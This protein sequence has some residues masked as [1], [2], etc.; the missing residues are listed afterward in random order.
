MT[1]RAEDES[2]ESTKIGPGDL[3]AFGGINLILTLSL[4][5]NDLS[6]N[7]INW[8]DLDSLKKLKF[9]RKHKHFWNRVELSSNNE[10]LDILLNI[11]KTSQK[12]IK[13]GYVG[14][15]K[16]VYK[17][18]QIEFEDFIISVAKQNG[19][20]LTSC[21]VCKCTISIQL[22]LKYENQEKI[23]LL[24]G[25][26]TDINKTENNNLENKDLN[27]NEGN[28]NKNIEEDKKNGNNTKEN[29]DKKNGNEEKTE[30]NKEN[31]NNENNKNKEKENSNEGNK[32]ESKSNEE[33]EE[34]EEEKNPFENLADNNINCGEFNYIYFNFNDYT[35]GE[36]KGKIKIHHLFEYFQDIKIR[37][38]SKIILNFEEEAEV[39]KNQNKDEIFKDLLS[40]TDLFIFYNKKKLYEVLKD[41]KEEEDKEAIDES[42]KFHCFEAQ[43]KRE[44]KEKLRQKEEEWSKNYKMFL[45]KY[46]KEKKVPKH[47]KTDGS[48]NNSQNIYITQE[49]RSIDRDSDIYKILG[50]ETE[51]R[52][53]LANQN[54]NKKNTENDS[55][56]YY[57]EIMIHKSKSEA[58]KFK[59]K[60]IKPSNPKPLNKNDMFDYFKNGIFSRDPQKRPTEKIILVLDEFNKIFI[61]K[62]NKLEEKPFVSDFDLKLYPK[63]NVRNMNEILDYK[64]FIKNNFRK[65]VDIFFGSFLSVVTGNG[66]DGCDEDSLF[67][68]YL[69]ATNTV[70]KIAEIQRFNLPLPNNK[71]FFSPS[72]NKEE[73]DR[74]LIEANQKRKENAFI[75]DGNTKRDMILKPYNPL[76]DKNLGT[77]LN[78]KNNKNFLQ[79]NGFV[80]KDG[81]IIYDPTYRET[82]GFNSK[83]RAN[84]YRSIPN[85]KLS[86]VKTKKFK[87]VANA[88]NKFLAGFRAKSPGYSIYNQRKAKN[89]LLPPIH[90]KNKLMFPNQEK[91]ELLFEKIEEID[92]SREA[93]G[94]VS[95]KE[96]FRG[97]GD[98]NERKK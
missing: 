70:K 7:N 53:T 83:N 55:R 25:I 48:V 11:N 16:L 23:F 21:D 75:L 41:L 79:I 92:G 76:L 63:M 95:E 12:Q 60:P 68:G 22:L 66:K 40:I 56:D 62:C 30:E 18:N 58:K 93:S 98:S 51:P 87:T 97:S 81:K 61:V 42:Y 67:L 49:P 39:F 84:K 73:L 5:K 65:Y 36:F 78:S 88:T 38:N 45:E 69:I 57:R 90:L 24:S 35:I 94:N 85:I 8:E 47:L 14:F 15:K 9:I 37:T 96:S 43:K 32:Q 46:E 6:K 28:N 26:S 86:K 34:N 91:K 13:I 80:G 52:N 29:E 31:K 89:K 27:E 64:K 4:D 50:Q 33:G 72:K 3:L 44:E 71:E 20:Y 17:D 59:L 19:L 10:T 1:N 2:E 54:I 74:L 82:L 77:F